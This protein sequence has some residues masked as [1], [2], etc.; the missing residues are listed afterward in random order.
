MFANIKYRMILKTVFHL[1]LNS[2]ETTF[3]KSSYFTKAFNHADYLNISYI[4][5]YTFYLV[6][7]LLLSTY[8]DVRSTERKLQRK[9]VTRLE[10]R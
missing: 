8:L 7:N 5:S 4:Y 2:I 1:N 3:S 9:K 6:Q 10:L